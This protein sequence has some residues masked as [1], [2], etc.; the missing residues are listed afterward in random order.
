MVCFIVRLNFATSQFMSEPA[1]LKL[2]VM[3]IILCCNMYGN[4][5]YQIVTCF[6]ILDFRTM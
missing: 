3:N 1:D 4:L 6:Q 2:L 5:I